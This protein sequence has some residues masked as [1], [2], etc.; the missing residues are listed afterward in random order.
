MFSSINQSLTCDTNCE[1]NFILDVEGY[2]LS[3]INLFVVIGLF[4]LRYRSPNLHRPFKTWIIVPIFFLIAQSFLLVAPFIRPPGGKGDTSLPYWL[5]P[6]VGIAVLLVGLGYWV[7]W[8]VLWPK[9]GGFRWVERKAE[10]RDGT[11]VTEFVK[12]K[13]VLVVY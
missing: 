12:S 7:V 8:R 10:L 5:Y 9:F 11:I 1:Q 4:I 3:I 2:P 6:I 13:D